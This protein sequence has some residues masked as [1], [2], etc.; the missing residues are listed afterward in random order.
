MSNFYGQLYEITNKKNNLRYFGIVFSPGKTFEKRL[1]EH[2]SGK[3]SAYIRRDI[4]SG[5]SKPSDFHARL[6]SDSFESL[7][8]LR[9][10][11]IQIIKDEN[12]LWP[13]GY[14]G[15]CGNQIVV[16]REL[17]IP[18][19][20]ESKRRL[21][22]EVVGKSAW[23]AGRQKMR[24]RHKT[25]QFTPNELAKY[26]KHSEMVSKNWASLSLEERIAKSYNG[27]LARN[28]KVTCQNCGLTTNKGNYSRWHGDNC[29]SKR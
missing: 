22:E 26:A 11:E 2:V 9:L 6:I 21:I 18:I 7:E 27:N 10:A 8:S 19:Y 12:T 29:K 4:E 15:N 5:N 14:N 25:K 28:E 23:L 20:Q 1:L 24:D 3:G 16:D 17:M 13:A